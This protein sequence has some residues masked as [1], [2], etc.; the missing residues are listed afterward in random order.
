MFND[1]I[2]EF[3]TYQFVSFSPI[4]YMLVPLAKDMHSRMTQHSLSDRLY[5]SNPPPILVNLEIDD[6][7]ILRPLL[8][9]FSLLEQV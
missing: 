9:F 3:L 2:I 6:S 4:L 8:L 1:L 5:D 7:L